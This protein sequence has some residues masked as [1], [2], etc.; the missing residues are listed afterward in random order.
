MSAN[1]FCCFYPVPYNVWK[2]YALI[3]YFIPYNK[4]E[5][6]ILNTHWLLNNNKIIIHFKS[7]F[8]LRSGSASTDFKNI[9]ETSDNRTCSNRSGKYLLRFCTRDVLEAKI[10]IL[11]NVENFF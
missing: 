3:K 10:K 7:S 6:T 8:N 4:N 9:G 11:E 2:I 1:R 5:Y